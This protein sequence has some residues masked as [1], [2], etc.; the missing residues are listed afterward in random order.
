MSDKT[1][2]VTAVCARM[3]V[4]HPSVVFLLSGCTS[5]FICRSCKFRLQCEVP[6]SYLCVKASLAGV[7]W[8]ISDPCVNQLSYQSYQPL[9]YVSVGIVSSLEIHEKEA[10]HWDLFVANVF[11]LFE[12]SDWHRNSFENSSCLM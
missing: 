12:S 9:I 2:S 8:A 5:L 1:E 3:G 11:P 4:S 6:H 7:D 10:Q